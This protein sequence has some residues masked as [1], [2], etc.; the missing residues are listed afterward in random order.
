MR[1][2]NNKNREVYKEMKKGIFLWSLL[3]CLL[4]AGCQKESVVEEGQA[5]NTSFIISV[6]ENI[7]Y[8]STTDA[9]F[10]SLKNSIQS[11]IMSGD[12]E[13][14]DNDTE[15]VESIEKA[16]GW[17]RNGLK[18]GQWRLIDLNGDG[19]EDLILEEKE[20]V[21]ADSGKKRII[22]IFA[23]YE[24]KARCVLW[25]V[26]DSTEY[27]FCGL[28]GELMYSA[29]SYG[30]VVSEEP[31]THYYFD[32]E[33]NE[34]TD[35]TIVVYRI[36]AAMNEEYAEKWRNENPDMAEDG[37]YF[38]KYTEEGVEVLTRKELESIYEMETGY[39]FHS[40]FY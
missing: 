13:C 31:Y 8:L 30:G 19:I 1:F 7:W 15:Y 4:L 17:T 40:E 3:G 25:D 39:E 5:D 22:G 2:R 16:Y 38:R 18:D 23:C 12:F 14:L 36:D 24:D 33:W 11:R 28:T 26:N 20:A 29:S 32:R 6:S 27:F 35:Y 9:A 34:I 21:T 37:I 10:Y